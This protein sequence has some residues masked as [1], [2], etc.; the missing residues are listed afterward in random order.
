MKKGHEICGD[1]A[2]QDF[3]RGYP[4]QPGWPG[5]VLESFGLFRQSFVLQQETG[6]SF[7]DAPIIEAA[8]QMVNPFIASL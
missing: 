3:G 1:H 2:W 4:D 8:L 5:E 6:Y 7:Y